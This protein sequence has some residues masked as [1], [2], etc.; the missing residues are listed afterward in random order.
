MSRLRDDPA[1]FEGAVTTA[2]QSLGLAPLFVEK[3]YWVT[4][5]LRSLHERYPGAFVLKGGTSLSKGYGLIERFSEDVDILM[6]P[7]KGDSAASRER[8]LAQIAGQVAVDL[9]MERMDARPPGRGRGAHRADVMRYPR[10]IRTGV[11]VPIEDRG[12]LL[13]S[14]YAGGEWPSEMVRL[15]PMLCGPLDLDPSEYEDTAAFDVK[16]C[17]RCAHCLRRSLCC[18]TRQR[19]MRPTHHRTSAAGATTTT[20]T[21]YSTMRPHAR[22]SRTAA[23]SPASSL[24]QRRSQAHTMEAG[25][26]DHRAATRAGAPRR[27]RSSV[28]R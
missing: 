2:A 15:T 3:D 14:R 4:Q 7:A 24:R 11:A 8:L 26:S 27:R 10:L 13:E 6:L 28:L 12:V 21:V 16:P 22:R 9:G 5:V 19:H 23:S 18:T 20:S 1:D 25:A 17:G